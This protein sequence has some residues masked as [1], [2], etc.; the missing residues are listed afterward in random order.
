MSETNSGAREDLRKRAPNF[1]IQ[2][3]SLLLNIVSNYKNIVENKETNSTTWRDKDVAWTKIASNFNS[4]TR[5][6]IRTK[7]Q[8]KKVYDNLKQVTRKEVAEENQ[9]LNKTGG[10]SFTPKNN[11][12]RELTLGLINT[13]T[14]FGIPFEF[15]GDSQNDA[16]ANQTLA[17]AELCRDQNTLS[18][19]NDDHHSYSVKENIPQ[20]NPNKII[21]N[22]NENLASDILLVSTYFQFSS[23]C[24]CIC[25]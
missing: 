7:G 11:P 13:K 15:G 9:K 16:S 3:K 25:I 10:G 18:E 14:V 12:L 22:D 23:Y 24:L 1:S 4:Q 5:D 17:G 8:L 6:H 21:V 19:L 20:L 2:E